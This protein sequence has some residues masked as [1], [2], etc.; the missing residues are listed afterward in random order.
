MG[1]QSI[2]LLPLVNPIVVSDLWFIGTFYHLFCSN[3]CDMYMAF[4]GAPPLKSNP[5]LCCIITHKVLPLKK[6]TT[7]LRYT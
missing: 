4:D 3:R 2:H 5:F 6:L 1:I 7:L